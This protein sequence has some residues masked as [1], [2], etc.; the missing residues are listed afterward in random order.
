M[1]EA[2]VPTTVL[3]WVAAFETDVR[4]G[5]CS[6]TEIIEVALTDLAEPVPLCPACG[7]RSESGENYKGWCR[8]CILQRLADK[9]R[10]RIVELEELRKYNVAK[11]QVQ[12]LR[13]EIDPDRSRAHGP[14][15]K[16]SG[17]YGRSEMLPTDEPLPLA[18][19]AC[20]AVIRQHGDEVLCVRCEER[21]EA[22]RTL[23][24]D[25]CAQYEK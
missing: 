9:Q 14:S 25:G 22:R 1:S 3:R 4:E 2:I 12:R 6:L 5:K 8:V 16:K 11:K 17:D 15:T 19:C 20:G 24:G 10:D 21:L 23:S 7:L 13:D 18:Y